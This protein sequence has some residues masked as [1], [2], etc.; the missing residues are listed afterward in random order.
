MSNIK[1]AC[2]QIACTL[3]D[4][5]ANLAKVQTLAHQAKQAGTDLIVF[6]E[7]VDTGYSMEVIRD[8]ASPWSEGFVPSLERLSRELSMTIV[9]GV[10]E[11]ESGNIFN[12]QVVLGPDG[13]VLARYRKTH[14]FCTPPIQEQTCFA[15][16]GKFVSVAASDLQLGLS[17]CYDLRFPE[18]Y[19][20][21]A[22][23]A[24]VDGFILSSAWPLAR[25]PHLRILALARAIENQGYL[26]LANRV[27][28]DVGVTFGGSSMIIDPFGEIIT[29][30]SE[31]EETLIYAEVCKDRVTSVR[32]QI[33]VFQHRRQDLYP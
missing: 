11:R 9:C 33:Q 21:L 4:P 17:I 29:S 27:G 14:L 18:Q 1:I 7:M 3:G 19:R 10:S 13:T 25:I 24:R 2:A 12:S 32:N 26:M 22:L 8:I 28:T 30:A 6:P 15:A 16:G 31:S 5:D 23:Q 20:H